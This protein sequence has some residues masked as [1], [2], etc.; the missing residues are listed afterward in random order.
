MEGGAGNKKGELRQAEVAF[1]KLL[2]LGAKDAVWHAHANLARVSIDLGKL[3]DAAENVTK[4]GQCDP[5]APWWLRAWLS[6]STIAEN[7]TTPEDWDAAAAEFAKIVDPANQPTERN[8]N[9]TKDYVVLGRLGQAYFRRYQQTTDKAGQLDHLGKAI[10]AYMKVLAVD[11]EDV[12]SHDGLSRCYAALGVDAPAGGGP[13]DGTAEEVAGLA[14][15]ATTGSAAERTG[16]AVKLADAVTAFGRKPPD[17]KSP[18]LKPLQAA[19]ERVRTAY[20]AETDP[21]AKAALA[22]ALASIHRE[23]QNLLKPDE[24]AKS[25]TMQA[26]RSK[27]PAHNAAAEAIVIYPTNRK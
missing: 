23:L 7:A 26:Y 20:A 18:R 19:R 6:G 5:P 13:V 4:S 9:F 22:I 12:F 16:A 14:A 25:A 21:T 17:A 1:R 15:A 11:P 8:M 2:T 10:N 24:L 3:K 27:H